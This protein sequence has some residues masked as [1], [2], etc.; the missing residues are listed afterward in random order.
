[1]AE[2]KKELDNISERRD[3]NRTDIKVLEDEKAKL[4]HDI[5]KKEEDQRN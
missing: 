2:G 1:M 5:K 3:F 4:E